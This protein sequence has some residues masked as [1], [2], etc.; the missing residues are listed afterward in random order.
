MIY[1]WPRYLGAKEMSCGTDR[2]KFALLMHCTLCQHYKPLRN[3]LDMCLQQQQQQTFL[4]FIFV[5]DAVNEQ[6][7]EKKNGRKKTYLEV[8]SR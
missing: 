3:T 4:L 8:S 5:F 6:T 7:N 1:V 2:V